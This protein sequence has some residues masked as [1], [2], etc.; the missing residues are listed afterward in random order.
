MGPFPAT[1]ALTILIAAATAATA[2]SATGGSTKRSGL[3]PAMGTSPLRG[4]A[5]GVIV[6]PAVVR[7]GRPAT[8]TVSGISGASL[9]VRLAGATT[10]RGLPVGWVPLARERGRWQGTLPP[11]ALRGV[12]PI[13]I[14]RGA[15]T[16][17]LRSLRWRLL[18]LAVGT[19][20][21]PAFATPEA[22]AAWWVETVPGLTSHVVATRRWRLP[23]R[24]RRDPRLH[25]LLVVAYGV[26]GDTRVADRLGIWITAFRDRY[27]GRWRLLEATVE[28][29]A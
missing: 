4:R 2:A 22:V 10:L 23:A 25:R 5:P 9:E 12:Y 21:R 19:L 15:G 16:R 14:R 18:V 17:I 13:E 26:V 29:P 28:P 11:P 3:A 24:D 27:S 20:G 6:Q 1:T 8:I 7:L